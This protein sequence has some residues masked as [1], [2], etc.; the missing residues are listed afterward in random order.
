MPSRRDDLQDVTVSTPRECHIRR[1]SFVYKVRGPPEGLRR[2][3]RAMATAVAKPERKG[4]VKGGLWIDNAILSER[5]TFAEAVD[6]LGS[7]EPGDAAPLLEQFRFFRKVLEF[8]EGAEDRDVF[9][10]L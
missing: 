5:N 3:V 1:L 4:P 7:Q 10:L 2:G 8:H 9:R 6:R